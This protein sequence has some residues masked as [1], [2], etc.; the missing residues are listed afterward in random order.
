MKEHRFE[1][2]VCPDCGSNLNA[3]MSVI[4]DA[5][6]KEGDITVCY[7]CGCA[8]A[9]DASIK[10]HKMTEKELSQLDPITLAG[11]EAAVT[12]IRSRANASDR[13]DSEGGEHD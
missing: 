2:V 5:P 1:N 13:A 8:L 10:L 9:F 11:L 7:Y 12:Q 4:D 6:P 3:G